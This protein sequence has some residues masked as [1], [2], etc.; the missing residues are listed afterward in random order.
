LVY[1]FSFLIL[2][3]DF[4]VNLYVFGGPSSFVFILCL[5]S[6]DE[7]N[8]ADKSRFVNMFFEKNIKKYS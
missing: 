3:L 5:F 7:Y 6:F 1:T 8:I 4:E 2:L